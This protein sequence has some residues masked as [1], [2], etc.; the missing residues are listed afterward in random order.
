MTQTSLLRVFDSI[1]VQDVI[2]SLQRPLQQVRLDPNKMLAA[3][4][5][6]TDLPA[7]LC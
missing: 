6:E 1:E 5:H 2:E 4:N 7:P 3:I